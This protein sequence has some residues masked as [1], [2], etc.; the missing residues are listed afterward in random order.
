MN[1]NNA[2]TWI[3]MGGATLVVLLGLATWRSYQKRQSRRL[4]NRFGAEYDRTVIEMNGRNEGESNLKERE[5]R[6]ERFQIVPLEPAEADKFFLAWKTLQA[7]FIDN[8]A[9]VVIRADQLVREL[10]LKRGYPLGDFEHRA[11][12]LSVDHSAVV[13]NYR[14]A[15]EIVARVDRGEASTEEKRMAV[16]H[17]R[18]LFNELAV[19]AKIKSQIV[20]PAE[21]EMQ[22]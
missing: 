12:D 5:K 9:G 21:M 6:V 14:A 10:M 4:K 20:R 8:P 16:V 7:G 19:T 13:Q 15:H 22:P 3:I 18:T 17:L 11:A 2:E 1:M